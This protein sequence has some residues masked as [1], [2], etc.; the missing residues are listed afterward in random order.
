MYAVGPTFTLADIGLG[1]S[2]NRWNMTP[3]ERPNYPA[4]TDYLKRL[5]RREGFQ[6]YGENGVA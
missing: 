5:G 6:V 3:M 1:L 4:I 2:A